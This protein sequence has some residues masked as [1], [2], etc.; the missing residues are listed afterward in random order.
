[1]KSFKKSQGIALIQVL[2]ISLILTMLGIYINQT[3]RS[4]INIVSLMKDS[5]A[6][7][8]QLENAEAE[9]LHALLTHKR[10]RK[11][12]SDNALVQRWN[13]Y[14]EPF[15]LDE[16]TTV[17]LQD[18]SGLLGLNILDKT[19][20]GK[21]F[22]QFDV[23]GHD[24]RTFLDS[25]A[26]W[27]DKDNLKHLNGAESTY[28]GYLKQ[29]GPRNAYLQTLG[30]VDSIQKGDILTTS[31]WQRYFTE[32]VVPRFNP[33]NA[34][35]LILKAF[36]NND[37]AYEEVLSLRSAKTLTA[38]SF[39]QATSIDDD[40]YISFATGRRLKV[41]LVVER[42]NNKLSKQFVVDLRPSSFSRPITISQLT[43]NKV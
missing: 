19:L 8:L 24:T 6:L 41:T 30:E 29:P 32:E 22:A 21:F 12:D 31:Q 26:D 15:L 36:I 34:P 3:V 7:N 33:I 10:Y 16:N 23:S 27:K 28:Y 40:E 39:Y 35:E 13:F 20:A 4:Q 25:L 37:S 43:W 17:V 2:I 42:Q 14:G 38:F 5:F 9:L 18:L 11:S 1:M